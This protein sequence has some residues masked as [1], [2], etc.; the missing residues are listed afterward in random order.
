MYARRSC[1][2][3]R[4]SCYI[5]FDYNR[6]T[7]GKVTRQILYPERLDLRSYM[8]VTKGP[9]VTYQLYAVLTH[10]GHSAGSGHYF[11]N[12]RAPNKQWFTMNDQHVS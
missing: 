3:H 4:V 9:P 2:S 7:G 6:M 8:S 1:G 11:C 5:R 10:V 12:I